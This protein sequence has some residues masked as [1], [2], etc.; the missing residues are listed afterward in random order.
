MTNVLDR[1]KGVVQLATDKA[2]IAVLPK[3]GSLIGEGVNIGHGL[4]LP[5]YRY[6]DK[7]NNSLNKLYDIANESRKRIEG[8]KEGLYNADMGNINYL[9]RIGL[10][11]VVM[12]PP[13]PKQR[14]PKRVMP[15]NGPNAA[16][17]VGNQG[18][19]QVA[20]AYPGGYVNDFD[21]PPTFRYTN[22]Q[23]PMHLFLP[24]REKNTYGSL[25]PMIREQQ[26]PIQVPD[27]EALPAK[28]TVTKKRN[29]PINYPMK[30]EP[31]SNKLAGFKKQRRRRNN[32]TSYKLVI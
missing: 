23:M 31:Q 29:Q 9:R 10:G 16:F 17:G 21:G 26:G 22:K 20:P 19:K 11:N 15:S 4:L 27:L 7:V 12:S 24:S 13:R 3:L 30:I 25:G 14:A 2:K 18:P 1:I 28:F 32:N 6:E 8:P 5:S